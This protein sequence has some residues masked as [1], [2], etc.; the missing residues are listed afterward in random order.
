MSAIDVDYVESVLLADGW[1][2]VNEGSFTL[3]PYQFVKATDAQAAVGDCEVLYPS[4]S[5]TPPLGFAFT[6]QDSIT[7]DLRRLGGPLSSIIAVQY[8][9]RPGAEVE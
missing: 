1:H 4:P 8:T 2:H 7:G 6:E 5:G 3:D 9:A